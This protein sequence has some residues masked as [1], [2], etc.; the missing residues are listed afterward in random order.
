MM[1]ERKPGGWQ[2]GTPN[3]VAADVRAAASKN[4]VAV[5]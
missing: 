4:T 5:L 2:K 3:K 1:K